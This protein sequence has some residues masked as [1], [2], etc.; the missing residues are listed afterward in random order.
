MKRKKLVLLSM[1]VI[2]ALALTG[3]FG[4]KN[5]TDEESDL[6]AEYSAGVLLRHSKTYQWRLVTKEQEAKENGETADPES[7]ALPTEEPQETSAV[8]PTPKT[9]SGLSDGAGDSGAEEPETKSVSLDAVYGVDGVKFS[10]DG[11]EYC[12]KYKNIQTAYKS[13]E[14]LLVIKFKLHNNSKRTKKVNF[15]KRD[16]TYPVTIG[17]ETYSLG[18][19]ILEGNDM[20]FLD[21][22]IPS[23]KSITAALVYT[24]PSSVKESEGIH[25][26]IQE[27]GKNVQATYD[28]KAD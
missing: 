11:A 7:S 25:L 18:I 13:G 2:S 6:I 21:V 23:G 5:V 9:D 1:L 26:T 16:F 24:V 8:S 15:M 28:L 27:N 4:V 20:K 10:I 19:N 3:C 22:S 17:S 14:K 12:K